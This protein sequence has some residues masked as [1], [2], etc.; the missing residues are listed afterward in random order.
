[1]K[2][3]NFNLKVCKGFILRQAV[4]VNFLSG[5]YQSDYEN[6]HSL[7]GNGSGKYY[8]PVGLYLVSKSVLGFSWNLWWFDHRTSGFEMGEGQ[9]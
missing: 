7:L 3:T 2:N 5:F 6:R 4:W 8:F 1:L 9:S